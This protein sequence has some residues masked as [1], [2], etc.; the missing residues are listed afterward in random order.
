M[1]QFR[2]FPTY[3]YL[4]QYML[5]DLH[6]P[7]CPIRKSSDITSAYD[8]PKLIAVNHVLL[9]LPVPRHSPCALCSLTSFFM[10]SSFEIVEFFTR[11][12]IVFYYPF[13]FLKYCVFSRRSTQYPISRLSCISLFS[14]QGALPDSFK[15]GFQYLNSCLN[16]EIRFQKKLVG[17]NGL[18]PST[19]RLSGGRSNLLSYKPVFF[20][21]VKAFV[22]GPYPISLFGGDNRDRTDDPLLAKQ[23]LSQL[24]YTPISLGSTFSRFFTNL[25]N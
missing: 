2:R 1:F 24:S 5:T 10:R 7:G 6:L 3:T 15:P 19:S 12:K 11:L 14:F 16:T 8:S 18:E 13:L 21:R 17:L 23:V 9:R 25:K 4:I 20:T 22:S